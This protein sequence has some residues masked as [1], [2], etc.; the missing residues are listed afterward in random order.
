MHRT[1]S[2]VVLNPNVDV[3]PAQSAIPP[4][5]KEVVSPPLTALDLLP[6][7]ARH[8]N[9]AHALHATPPLQAP[10]PLLHLGQINV[11]VPVVRAARH[12]PHDLLGSHNRRRPRRPRPVHGAQDQP[13]AGLDVLEAVAQEGRGRRHVLHDLEA[14]D[15]VDA[16]DGVVVGGGRRGVLVAR[17]RQRQR[18]GQVLDGRV[19]VGEAARREQQRVGPLMLLCD[20]EDGRGGVDGGHGARGRQAGGRLGEDAAAAADVQVVQ[21]LARRC[22]R[23]RVRV[24]V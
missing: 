24:R 1:S 9:N 12:Y 20:G 15:D 6:P 16:A 21:V 22:R 23:G 14:G 3:K 17:Q 8:V 13:A 18:H 11:L 2:L 7:E 5:S 19:E 10:R 4:D